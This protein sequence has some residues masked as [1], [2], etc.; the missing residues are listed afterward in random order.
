MP[1][2]NLLLLG[3]V[4]FVGIASAKDYP[5]ANWMRNSNIQNLTLQQITIAG[6]HDSGSYQLTDELFGFPELYEI[7]AEIADKLGIPVTYIIKQWSQTQTVDFY[8]QFLDGIRYVDIRFIYDNTTNVWKLHHSGVIGLPIETMLSATR[9]FLQNYSSEVLVLEFSHQSE[10]TL[11]QEQILYKLIDQYLGKYLWPP[12]M[13]I[14]TIGEMISSGKNVIL[15]C[16]LP[17]SPDTLWNGNTIINSWAQSA[18]LSTMESYNVAQINS[19]EKHG[20]YPGQLYKMSWTLTPNAETIIEMILP[21]FPH[22]VIEL[23]DIA[24]TDLQNFW[25]TKI[26]PNNYKYPIF[27]N[28]LIIDDFTNSPIVELVQRGLPNK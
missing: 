3:L 19:W 6:T 22:T 18:D 7:M 11:E 15:T 2:I 14:K 21:D 26:V 16:T 9:S 4:I 25:N 8:T 1:Q 28:I 27:S 20:I 12:S 23:A 13:G 24:N 5:Y 10:Q 17:S